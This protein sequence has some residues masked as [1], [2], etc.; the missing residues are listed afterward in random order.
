MN[1]AIVISE[2]PA[3]N[4]T[5]ILDHITGLLDRGHHVDIY[6]T[7]PLG[8][9]KIHQEI[10][11]YD[12]LKRTVYR[13]QKEFVVPRNK[14]MRAL[15]SVP[16]IGRG[17][18]NN[19]GGTLNSLNVFR[20]GR[21]AASLDALYKAGPFISRSGKYDIVHCHFAENG[22][23]AVRMRQMGVISG[24]IITSFHGYNARY[25]SNGKIWKL[26]GNL[27]NKGDLF[28]VCSEHMKAWFARQGWNVGKTVVHRYGVRLDR[29]VPAT[30]RM[31]SRA[32][33][34]LLSV[35]RLVQKKGFEY[36]IRGVAKAVRRFPEIRYDIAGD[37]P[38]KPRLDRLIHQLDMT[39]NIRLLGW[40]N[41]AEVCRLLAQAQLLLTPSITAD[42]GDQEGIPLVLHEA[43]ASG[44][45][46]VAT[47]HT[48]IPELVTDGESGFLVEEKDPD[49]IAER[50]IQLMQHPE[51]W[52]EM[53]QKGRRHIEEYNDLEKQTDR[54]VAIYRNL[55]EGHFRP[56]TM[57]NEPRLIDASQEIRS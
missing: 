37:G 24:K 38:E 47:R 48:G 10:E 32:Q 40:Q 25:F 20:F 56:R 52:E 43:M 27:A 49:A 6:A 8:E 44:I 29:F 15:K 33:V 53:G 30:R 22:E 34:R 39:S 3:L 1:I 11:S 54:L 42:N 2:F 28:L 7:A 18:L 50:L 9:P 13:D 4:E 5:F 45:P 26:Y 35:G 23:L 16:L 41:R 55:S 31:D 51:K 36:S 14:L 21:M 19:A 17:L 12:L 46:T 57:Q